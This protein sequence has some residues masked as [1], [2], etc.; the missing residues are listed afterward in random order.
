MHRPHRIITKLPL[1]S[2]WDEAGRDLQAARIRDLD[3]EAI[4]TLLRQMSF[5]FVVANVGQ[6]L[7]WRNESERCS[8]WKIEVKDHMFQEA[9]P[10]LEDYPSEY[11][12]HASEW[13]LPEGDTV[14]VLEMEH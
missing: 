5:R 1:D 4:R 3:R 8:F 7:L 14:V 11:Y 13:R 10:Y 9:C 12:Y 2:L 6:I